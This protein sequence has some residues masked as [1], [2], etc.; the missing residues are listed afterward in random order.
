M[1]K[2]MLAVGVVLV[3]AGMTGAERAYGDA[4]LSAARY[5]A[6]V[7]KF[8]DTVLDHGRDH[9]GSQSTPLFVDGLH[10]TT[11]EPTIWKGNGCE[12]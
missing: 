6:A 5:V 2:K 7:R 10:A 4:E 11:L 12:D 3:I 8:A 9:Y 1:V